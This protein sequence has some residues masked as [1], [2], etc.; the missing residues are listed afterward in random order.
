MH[1]HSDDWQRT[2][3]I[4]TLGVK[5]TEFDLSDSKKRKLKESGRKGALEYFKWFDKRTNKAVNRP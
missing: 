1:L 4:D 5:T 3:Y 2:V